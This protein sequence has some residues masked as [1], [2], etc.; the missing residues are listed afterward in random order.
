MNFC[1][2]ESCNIIKYNFPLSTVCS[3]K[4]GGNAKYAFFPA[5]VN[6]LRDIIFFLKKE[7]IKY[8]IH[9]SG[10]NVIYSD[11]GYDGAVVVTRDMKN[12]YAICNDGDKVSVDSLMNDRNSCSDTLHVY[13]EAGVS[14]TSFAKKMCKLGYCGLEFAYGIPASIGGAV[15]M[16]AGAYGGEMGFVLESVEYMDE[17]GKLGVLEN[18]AEKNHFTYRHSWFQE[19]PEYVITGV[20]FCLKKSCDSDPMMLAEKNMQARKEK[21]PLEYPSCGSAFKRPE[22]YYAGAL[23]Q[24]AGLKGYNIGGAYV[25]EKHAGFIVNKGG[26]TTADVVALLKYVREKVYEMSGVTL[27]AEIKIVAD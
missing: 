17:E 15:Y 6:R 10:S 25:S 11:S 9:G 2:F 3:M 7:K 12:T 16:N 18:R 24:E 22:G 8:R 13:A 23:I 20:V 19:H 4:T 27:E 21:Q 14:L 5:D 26:A 1:D